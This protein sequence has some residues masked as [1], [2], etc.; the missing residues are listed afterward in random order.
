MFWIGFYTLCRKEMGRFLRI[1]RETLIPPA[2]T[3]V[4]YFVI[5]GHLVGSQISP[6]HGLPYMQYIAPGLVMM[7]VI[8]SSFANTINS[9]YLLR[10]QKSIEEILV[11]PMPNALIL[12]GFTFGGVIRGLTIGSIVMLVS[13]LLTKLVVQHVFLMLLTVFLTAALFSLIGFLFGLYVKNFDEISV[14][15]TFVLT[16]LTYLGGVFYSINMLS[17]FWQKVSLL[18]PILYLVNAFRYSLLGVTDIPIFSAL[19]FTSLLVIALFGI[20]YY[21]L[22]KST[23][24]RT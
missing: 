14:F 7:T 11:S 15:P 12:L 20:N 24:L 4:L 22:S 17:P 18:N 23:G 21:L 10:F 8:S 13:L 1:W 3:M 16:P 9:I 2:I 19:L 5:F 6:I